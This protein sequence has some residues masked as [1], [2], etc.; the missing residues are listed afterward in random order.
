MKTPLA[1]LQLSREK[2]R[3][4]IALAG[5][6]FADILMFMQLGFKS[7]L[8]NSSIRLHEKVDGDIFLINPQSTA[9]IAMKSFSS[10]RL[11]ESAGVEG[12]KSINALYIGFGIWKNPLNQKTRQILVIGFNPKEPVLNLEGISENLDKLSLPDR[13]LFDRNSRAEFGPIGE[14]YDSGKE[15]KTEIGSR[16]I[17]VDGLFAIGSTF[18]ADGNVV[19]SDLNF[20]RIFPERDKN[21]IDAGVIKLKENANRQAIL[22]TLK[23]KFNAGDVLVLSKEE[24]FAHEKN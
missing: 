18:G 17:Q 12:V 23:Q 21:L 4:L 7:A 13:V 20:L 24:F 11:Y 10:R 2:I 9:L 6:G 5:I 16:Q 15:I 19:T 8:L 22:N 3:L 14:L 1:W